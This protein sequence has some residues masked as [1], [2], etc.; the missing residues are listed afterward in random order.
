MPVDDEPKNMIFLIDG[1]PVGFAKA[2]DI[3]VPE[4]ADSMF[5]LPPSPP[6]KMEGCIVLE[7]NSWDVLGSVV[8]DLAKRISDFCTSA[9]NAFLAADDS[10][11]RFYLKKFVNAKYETR[12]RSAKKAIVYHIRRKSR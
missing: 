1:Q 8:E 3:I 12:F 9:I 2:E 11:G 5:L 4:P 6:L 7:P 10:L